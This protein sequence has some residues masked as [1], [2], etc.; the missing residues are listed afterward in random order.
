MPLDT[1]TI[2][3][4]PK[5]CRTRTK[6]LKERKRQYLEECNKWCKPFKSARVIIDT[7]NYVTNPKHRT[8]TEIKHENKIADRKLVYSNFYKNRVV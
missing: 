6:F 3:T 4:P 5:T 1:I 8:Y 7:E 2:R